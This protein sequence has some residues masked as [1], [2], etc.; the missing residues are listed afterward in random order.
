MTR[1]RRRR[2]KRETERGWLK[3]TL[4]QVAKEVARWPES[5]RPRAFTK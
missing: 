4:E 1:K 2:T 3:P 5:V